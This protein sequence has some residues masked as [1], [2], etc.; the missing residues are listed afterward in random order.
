MNAK[1]EITVQHLYGNDPEGFDAEAWLVALESE[2]RSTALAH[3]PNAEV[4]VEID[5]QQRASGYCRPVSVD[6][7]GDDGERVFSPELERAI[8]YVAD[9]L[10]DTRGQEFFTPAASKEQ[11]S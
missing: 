4:I 3:F 9:A 10:Y 5:R 7:C 8:D 1:I 11:A 6:V 2:Y